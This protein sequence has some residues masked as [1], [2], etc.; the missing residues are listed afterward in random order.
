MRDRTFA[1]HDRV[2]PRAMQPRS[3]VELSMVALLRGVG[4]PAVVTFAFGRA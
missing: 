2:T 1:R 3:A 4:A